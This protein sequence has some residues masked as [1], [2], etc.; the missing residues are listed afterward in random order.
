M[1]KVENFKAGQLFT[2]IKNW[3]TLTKDWNMLN[4]IKG[5]SIDFINKPRAN[6]LP[7]IH[8]SLMKKKN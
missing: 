3:K 6:I 7:E 4:I 1:L 8:P 5:G 2:K